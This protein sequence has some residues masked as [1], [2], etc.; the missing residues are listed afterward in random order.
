MWLVAA[1][2]W[3]PDSQA[4]GP[5]AAAVTPFRIE[6]PDAEIDDLR[7]RLHNARWPEPETV[8]GWSQG[9]PRR[10][11]EELC[12]YWADGYDW[13]ATERRLNELPQF[14]KIG[15]AHV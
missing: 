13:R 11:L 12:R 6:V 1:E 2:E 4:G 7:A 10:W 15:R 14:R 3:D 9:V 5:G 8:P